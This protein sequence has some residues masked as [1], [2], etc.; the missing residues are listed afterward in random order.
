MSSNTEAVF[1]LHSAREGRRGCLSES[2]VMPSKP[3][4]IGATL[5]LTIKN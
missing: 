2:A 3:A 5:R 1:P 4:G